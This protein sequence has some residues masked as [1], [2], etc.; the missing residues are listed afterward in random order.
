MSV[1]TSVDG[2][3]A[4]AGGAAGIEP[5]W[6]LA[7]QYQEGLLTL[8]GPS[9]LTPV[10][11]ALLEELA[12]TVTR[13]RLELPTAPQT[14]LEAVE[15]LRVAEVDFAAVSGCIGRDMVLSALVLRQANSPLFA[16]RAA[17]SVSIQDALGRIGIRR[18]REVIL[19]AVLRRS[20]D[21]L[22][23]R[24]WADME[25]RYA[26]TCAVLAQRLGKRLKLDEEQCYTAGLLHDIGRLPLL[27]ALEQ[28]GAL[29][30]VPQPDCA[31]DIIIECLHRAVGCKVA[32]AWGLPAAV[33]DAT[34]HHL[35]GR[36]ADEPRTGE[37]LSTCVAEAASDLCHA[38]GIGRFPRPFAILSAP[39]FAHFG[40]ERRTLLAWLD[41]D[42]PA[43][44]NAGD[45]FAA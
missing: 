32:K 40:Q 3:A 16:G 35:N 9:R 42:V 5:Q 41:E 37:F 27:S 10:E 26:L 12:T 45:P 28:R 44:L 4:R 20:A 13:G 6:Y 11:R 36:L 22:R 2:I 7:P 38:L 8:A 14:A 18:M 17:R 30:D 29:P 24:A 15:A 25:W 34:S 1:Q 39:S 33:E 19:S 21:A 23:S 43:V 31:A